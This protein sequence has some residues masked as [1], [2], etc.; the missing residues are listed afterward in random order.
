[1]SNVVKETLGDEDADDDDNGDVKEIPLPNVAA[2]VLQKVIEYCRHH[3]DVEPMT[4]IQTP[5]KSTK[6]EDLVQKWYAEYVAVERDL[7]FDLVAAANYMDIKPL[8]DLTCLAV[9]IIIKGKSAAELRQMFN[10]PSEFTQEENAQIVRE[11]Q[12]VENAENA[13]VEADN[14]QSAAEAAAPAPEAS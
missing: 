7:L 12:W 1:M 8:L 6:L 4:T 13:E 2:P 5:L 14:N 11:N 10:I 3:E 9:S